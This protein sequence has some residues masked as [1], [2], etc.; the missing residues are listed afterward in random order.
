MRVHDLSSKERESQSSPFESSPVMFE[1]TSVADPTAG[2]AVEMQSWSTQ[3]L[4]KGSGLREWSEM[5]EMDM[6]LNSAGR[7]KGKKS[8]SE[9]S[10]A[11][12]GPTSGS[13]LGGSLGYDSG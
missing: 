10:K 13:F 6:K 7:D 12:V 5:L 9:W 8:G 4:L 11:K 1:G 2:D 3:V